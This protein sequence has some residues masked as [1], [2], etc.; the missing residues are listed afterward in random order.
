MVEQ[1]TINA[2]CTPWDALWVLVQTLES[3]PLV[4]VV[5]CHQVS[6]VLEC[7]T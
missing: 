6:T 4:G 3:D 2:S 1:S 5:L 7:P